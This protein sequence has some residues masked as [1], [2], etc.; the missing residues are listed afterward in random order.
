MKLRSLSLAVAL[1]VGATSAFADEYSFNYNTSDLDS[2]NGVAK[3]HAD[4]E[5]TAKAHCPTYNQVRSLGDIRAC[6]EDV[7]NALVEK[8]GSV[9]LTAYHNGESSEQIASL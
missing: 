9:K 3:V 7:I 5:A 2:Y 6:Q 4:I 8:I 1:T